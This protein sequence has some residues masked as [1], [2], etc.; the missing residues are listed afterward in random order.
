[1]LDIWLFR[2][3]KGGNSELIR[4]SQ[5]K[6][7]AD[8]TLVDQVIAKDL[9][10]RQSVVRREKLRGQLNKVSK[11]IG[12]LRK[13]GADDS[14]LRESTIEIKKEIDV[15]DSREAALLEERD[16]ILK[17]IGNLVEPHVHVSQNE[18]VNRVVST[19]EP[20]T[21]PEFPAKYGH[22]ELLHMIG[23]VDY[24]R[25]SKVAGNRGYFLTGPGVR[26]N[27]GLIMLGLN[28]LSDRGY[29]P[30][31]TPY[32]VKPEVMAATCQLSDFE[33]QLYGVGSAPDLSFLIATSEQP[34]SAFHMKE[35]LSDHD[36][37]RKYAGYSTCFRKEVGSHGRDT[38]GI[39]RTH[40]FDKV[41]QLCVTGPEKSQEMFQE[42]ITNAKQ[43]LELLELPYREVE[44]VSGALNNAAAIKH[45]L[46]AVF[47]HSGTFR[48]LV[49][50]SN[51][52]DYQSRRLDIRYRAF[53]TGP[54]KGAEKQYVHLLNSTLTATE[55]MLC[56][57]VE[58][59]QTESGVQVPL[60][61]R[62]FVGTDFLP[63]VNAVPEKK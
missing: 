26:L 18:E 38:L 55:R 8:V 44:I 14:E 42:M 13:A 9:E 58:H 2:D 29:T 45:D 10:W 61:L 47:R 52:T 22:V 24:E 28:F 57:I 39:F 50:C 54:S 32:M 62:P 15:I 21:P 16:D 12:K 60:A 43:F 51:C 36:L 35:W 25:G 1:M 49:S 7:F 27:M 40:Q 33:D 56:C 37:P 3:D 41:E 4:E 5:R 19:Y 20:S 17:R 59:Y 34:L 48:E 53:K 46:E 11:E 31:H 23:A 6:R 63:F 30:M